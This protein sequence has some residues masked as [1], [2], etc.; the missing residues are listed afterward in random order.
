MEEKGKNESMKGKEGTGV[1]KKKKGKNKREENKGGVKRRKVMGEGKARYPL[2]K[3][4]WS[5]GERVYS[6]E[7]RLYHGAIIKFKY[8]Y[9]VSYTQYRYLSSL[10]CYILTT[11]ESHKKVLRQC[12]CHHGIK[13]SYVFLHSTALTHPL[14]GT[15]ILL[16]YLLDYTMEKPLIFVFSVFQPVQ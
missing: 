6:E 7:V 9:L 13:K 2:S 15:A 4:G 14:N 8:L 5:V 12:P 10:L 1:E 3:G 16:L 11:L